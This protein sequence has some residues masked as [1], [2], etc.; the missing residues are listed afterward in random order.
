[1]T[2][3]T[4]D[5]T[6]FLK[7]YIGHVNIRYP[8]TDGTTM[9]AKFTGLTQGDGIETTYLEA[10]KEGEC[11]GDYL[12][13]KSNGDHNSNALNAKL[14][15]RKLSSMDTGEA[16]LFILSE[17]FYTSHQ[18]NIISV[19]DNPYI[20]IEYEI[21]YNDKGRFWHKYQSLVKGLTPA[22]F[23]YLL[24]KGF[25]LWDESYFTDGLI[26]EKP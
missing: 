14:I 9:I 25:W 12:A 5:I 15:V 3:N 24:S 19:D 18:V 8:D 1:M 6:P 20:G 4:K 17:P 21:Q 22:R 13:F 10:V 26:I 2:D 16:K 7:Y 11:K 23:H